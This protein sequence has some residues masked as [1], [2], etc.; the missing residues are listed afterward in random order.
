MKFCVYGAGA[1][2]GYLGL[3]LFEA[4]YEVTLID[5][6]AHLDAIRDNG[7][8][9]LING[10]TRTAQIPCTDAPET[11]PP[12]DYVFIAVKNYSISG[13]LERVPALFAAETAVVSVNNGLPWWYFYGQG[14]RGETYLESIDPGGRQWLELG[15]RRALGC[16]VYPA[17][18]VIAPGVIQ[19]ISGNRFA[20][21]EP[22]GEKSERVMQL[23]QAMRRGGLKAS[24]KTRIRDEVWIKLLGN[25]AFNPISVLTGATLQQICQQSGTRGLARDMMIEAKDVAECLGI[26]FSIDVDKRIDGAEAVGEHKTSML[27]DYEAGRPLETDALIT[28]VQ[29]LGILVGRETRVIDHVLAL[30]KLKESSREY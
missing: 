6:G 17:C 20:L 12:Q 5:R 2:G 29:E 23:A 15:A 9:L 11:L 18:Q 4:G 28:A 21:G 7:L 24:V 14:S 3:M 19:H 16:V 10:E 8:V 1:I 13:I 26:Q 30:L 22:S 25:L 27:Q